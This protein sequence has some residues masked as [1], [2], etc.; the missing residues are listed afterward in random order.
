MSN[1]GSN[2]VKL[3]VR[4]K[5]TV[6]PVRF[7]GEGETQFSVRQVYETQNASEANL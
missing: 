7:V 2:A 4:D 5:L 1:Q 6:D 3:Q